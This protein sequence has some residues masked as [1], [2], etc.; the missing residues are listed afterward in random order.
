MKLSMHIIDQWTTKA[1]NEENV[2]LHTCIEFDS[3]PLFNPGR[4]AGLVAYFSF[5][6]V[7]YK[8]DFNPVLYKPDFNPVL[9]KL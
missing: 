7:L 9:Y 5:Y 1:F 3:T 8:L 2:H 4:K 6:P